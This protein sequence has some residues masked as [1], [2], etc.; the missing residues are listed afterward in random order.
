[1]SQY[2]ALDCECNQPAF[3]ETMMDCYC[4]FIEKEYDDT[5]HL[6]LILCIV[7]LIMCC[8]YCGCSFA[9]P[10]CCGYP[11]QCCCEAFESLQHCFKRQKIQPKSNDVSCE[12]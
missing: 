1:M 12:V 6:V 2:E 11:F 8:C 10:E 3:N 9:F 4:K 5:F 7:G